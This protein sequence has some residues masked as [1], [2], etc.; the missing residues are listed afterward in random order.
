MGRED[1]S[2]TGK[3][4]LAAPWG[5]PARIFRD[6]VVAR[7]LLPEVVARPSVPPALT[8]GVS[9]GTP[10]P[11][12]TLPHAQNPDTAPS[13]KVPSSA[14]GLGSWALSLPL[15]LT[16][17][18]REGRGQKQ[19]PGASAKG[20]VK[21]PLELVLA[22]VQG[23]Q[24]Q[25]QRQK[26]LLQHSTLVPVAVYGAL[27]EQVDLGQV[28]LVPEGDTGA[29]QPCAGL[30]LHTYLNLFAG[31]VVVC[32]M[33]AYLAQRDCHQPVQCVFTSQGRAD[34]LLPKLP[35]VDQF[36]AQGQAQHDVYR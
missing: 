31:L 28:Q 25:G 30:K 22:V 35:V 21:A 7:M 10:G 4:P 32:C 36:F 1:S 2:G 17:G 13:Y 23:G 33:H 6:T 5:G 27:E 24:C 14:A 8:S 9:S 3:A 34:A 18:G 15:P 29:L 11:L 20:E 12:G 26:L 19:G 16:P